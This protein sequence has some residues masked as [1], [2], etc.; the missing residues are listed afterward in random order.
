MHCLFLISTF[1][2]PNWRNLPPPNMRTYGRQSYHEPAGVMFSPYTSNP[3]AT[4]TSYNAYSTPREHQY[5][6]QAYGT[7]PRGIIRRSRSR[8]DIYRKNK[9]EI[10]NTYFPFVDQIAPQVQQQT[11]MMKQTR[12][13]CIV[14][15]QKSELWTV[16]NRYQDNSG[17]C[18]LH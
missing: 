3:Y 7:A 15:G 5:A 13:S 14:D 17:Y 8:D 2:P 16:A 18:L 1:R 6:L 11:P 12:Q 10:R 4:T 9:I